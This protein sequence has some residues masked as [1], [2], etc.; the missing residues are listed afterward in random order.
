MSILEYGYSEYSDIFV[1]K[2]MCV[3]QLKSLNNLFL[4]KKNII[5]LKYLYYVKTIREKHHIM[6][7]VV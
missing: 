5:I 4:H 6:T 2:T 1:L 3:L 7:V